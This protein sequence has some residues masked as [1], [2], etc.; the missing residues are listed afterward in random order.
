MRQIAQIS[1]AYRSTSSAHATGSPS[2]AR[3]T[4]PAAV[5]SSRIRVPFVDSA[6]QY[7]DRQVVTRRRACP[8]PPS[9]PLGWLFLHA[10]C[11]LSR[12]SSFPFGSL[13]F[14]ML[15]A[16]AFYVQAPLEQMSQISARDPEY[17]QAQEVFTHGGAALGRALAHVTNARQPGLSRSVDLCDQR[18]LLLT[19]E[20]QLG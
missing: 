18:A 5:G 20:D 1:G 9:C 8:V 15:T 7:S 2:L 11:L 17:R 4:S 10:V 6:D 14:R 3:L 13:T 19:A 16:R 12:Y